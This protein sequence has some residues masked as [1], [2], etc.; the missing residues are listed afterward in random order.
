MERDRW[1]E[2]GEEIK[3]KINSKSMKKRFEKVDSPT[4]RVNVRVSTI[5]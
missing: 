3:I 4:E 5:T 1:G 2:G